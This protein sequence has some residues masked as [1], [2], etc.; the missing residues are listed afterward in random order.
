MSGIRSNLTCSLSLLKRSY[1]NRFQTI[2]VS[3]YDGAT[4]EEAGTVESTTVISQLSRV[5]ASK[6]IPP[7]FTPSKRKVV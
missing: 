7:V 5:T 4:C 6:M 2:Y 1:K 3:S